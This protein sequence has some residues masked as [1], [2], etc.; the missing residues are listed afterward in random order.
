MGA[1]PRSSAQVA[2]CC[3]LYGPFLLQVLHLS[4]LEFLVFNLSCG[5]A[6]DVGTLIAFR[7]LAGLGGSAPICEYQSEM[8]F[9]DNGI[10]T[11]EFQR[12]ARGLL[13]I[14]SQK[15]I[16]VSSAKEISVNI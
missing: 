2:V 5:F 1:Y 11:S 14:F 4:N 9:R 15:R 12:S 8:A 3:D 6:P 7:F 16:A 10:V 13:V